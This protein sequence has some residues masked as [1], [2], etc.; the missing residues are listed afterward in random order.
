MKK[1]SIHLGINKYDADYYGGNIDLGQCV[2]D[3]ERLEDYSTANGF[4]AYAMLNGNATVDNFTRKMTDAAKTLKKGDILFLTDSSHGTYDDNIVGAK[5]KRQTAICLH[6]GIFWD[7][8]MRELLKK[9]KAGVKV[10]WLSDCCFAESN[11][12]FIRDSQ[13][14]N[15]ARARY[16]PKPADAVAVPTQ[17]DKRSI[18]CN[19]F[20]YSSSNVYQVSYEDENGGVFTSSVLKA[21]S[22][23]PTISYYQ[24][25]KR[26]SEIIAPLYPQSPVFENVRSAHLTGTKFLT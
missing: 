13:P 7:Y 10:I 21:L 6:D 11:W 1:V 18:K 20:T 8:E 23:E 12:R 24:L 16:T 15:N 9:F 5:T 22:K 17:G 26:S 4:S 25:W 19:L 2:Y 3:A 14:Y